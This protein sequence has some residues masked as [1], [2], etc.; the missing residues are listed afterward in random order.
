MKI[1]FIASLGHSGST[2]LDL[3]LNAHPQLVS[4]GE[5][6]QL[7]R[8]A[9]FIP[10]PRKHRCTCMTESLW[11]CP[12]WSR[13]SALTEKAC[14]RT[15]GEL[16]VETYKD[17]ES[18]H[19]DNV[20]LFNAISAV[21]GKE[22]IVDSSKDPSR[23]RLLMDNPA[24]EVFPI[25][26][27][28]DPKGQICSSLR[29]GQNMVRAIADYAIINRRIYSSIKDRPHA[30]VRYED[31]VR[32]PEST[33]STLMEAI[34][35]DFNLVQLRWAEKERHN[36]GGNRMR[37]QKTSK[38]ELDDSWRRTLSVPRRLLIDFGASSLPSLILFGIS[39]VSHRLLNKRRSLFHLLTYTQR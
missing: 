17:P 32:N 5:L 2:L 1:I 14:G 19:S 12:F 20:E 6:K 31:L 34:G 7:S 27:L 35:L 30:V 39:Q 29:K 8:Y 9:R 16:N 3:M 10:P 38:L 25:F 11:D 37:R 23:L 4:V 33:L 22:Y 28:R 15:I 21:A 26:L 13:V 24:L 18:F 36:V